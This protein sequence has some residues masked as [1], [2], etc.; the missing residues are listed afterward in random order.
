MNAGDARNLTLQTADG[1]VLE[2]LVAGTHGGSALLFHSGTPSAAVPYEPLID[3]VIERG[4]QF[5]T[6][7]R[8]GYA[9]S[10]EH[11]GRSVADGAAD[12]ATI[13][14]ELGINS[15][16]TLGRSGGGPH[17]LACAAL[18]A[19]RCQAAATIAGVAPYPAAGLDWFAG[20]G[21]E[22][23]EE[24]TLALQGESA[25]VPWLNPQAQALTAIAATSVAAALGDLVSSVDVAALTGTLA[26]YAAA[27]FRRSV[28]TGI[29][30]WRDDDLA[31]TRPWGFMLETISVRVSV[32]QGDQ[33]RM[34]P[35][36][37]GEWLAAH[38]P[39]AV[40]H[41]IKGEGHLSLGEVGLAAVLDELCANGGR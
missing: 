20:M 41:L 5:V 8:P 32:W 40:A 19:E 2:V 18:L 4:L 38:I 21:R 28:S 9:G 11:H 25:L 31:F 39:G 33:D 14:A 12:V 3:A 7:S 10:T 36:A 23:I 34:V 37:H 29:A 30:G 22:N 16:V 35:P 24:F 1:R 17:A 27:S 26:D 6:Y 13:L 15:F